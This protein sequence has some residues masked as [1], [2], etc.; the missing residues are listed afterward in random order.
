[1]VQINSGSLDCW[2]WCKVKEEVGWCESMSEIYRIWR[3][4]GCMGEGEGSVWDDSQA[5]GLFSWIEG[6][7]LTR[8]GSTRRGYS[9][10]GKWR[11]CFLSVSAWDMRN[12]EG[13]YVC[14]AGRTGLRGDVMSNLYGYRCLDWSWM[15]KRILPESQEKR[16]IP[17][18]GNRIYKWHENGDILGIK[19]QRL[20]TIKTEETV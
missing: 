17:A 1:M 14:W 4:A 2:W 10:Q 6:S 3:M 5:S 7:V 16:S 9:L 19:F 11:I 13:G 8:Q 20:I 15:I 12:V 18:K